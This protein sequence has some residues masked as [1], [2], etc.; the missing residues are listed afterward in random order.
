MF[1]QH[2]NQIESET[3]SHSE[4]ILISQAKQENQGS[5]PLQQEY[6]SQRSHTLL[7]D[8]FKRPDDVNSNSQKRQQVIDHLVQMNN[9]I[10]SKT[11]RRHGTFIL[12][13][14]EKFTVKKD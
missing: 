3:F 11:S 5:E 14:T 9:S 4:L 2:Q 13:P 8:F 7:A 12:R 10:P 6:I 1:T